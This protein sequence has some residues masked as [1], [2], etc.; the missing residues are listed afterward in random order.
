MIYRHFLNYDRLRKNYGRHFLQDRRHL[1][2]RRLMKEEDDKKRQVD[3][4]RELN[5]QA[6]QMMAEEQGAHVTQPILKQ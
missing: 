5:E 3:L 2:R 6:Q 1:F 4:Q